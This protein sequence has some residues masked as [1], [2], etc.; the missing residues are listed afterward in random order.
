MSMKH[1][2]KKEVKM[3]WNGG[4]CS[5]GFSGSFKSLSVTIYYFIYC[6]PQNIVKIQHLK[7]PKSREF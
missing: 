4:I 5:A 2:N 7:I 3:W 6:E 1:R